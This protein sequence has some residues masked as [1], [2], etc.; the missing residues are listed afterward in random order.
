M[1]SQKSIRP[2]GIDQG[3]FSGLTVMDMINVKQNRS[4]LSGFKS[5]ALT[6]QEVDRR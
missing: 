5:R 1:K 4:P 2:V 3:G 6:R